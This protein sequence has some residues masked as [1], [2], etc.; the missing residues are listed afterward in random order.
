MKCMKCNQGV[1]L[2]KHFSRGE[3]TCPNCNTEY[4]FATRKGYIAIDLLSFFIG[5]PVL[6]AIVGSLNLPTLL[7]VMLYLA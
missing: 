6:L 2:K 4:V 7:D 1:P 3:Y 5:I